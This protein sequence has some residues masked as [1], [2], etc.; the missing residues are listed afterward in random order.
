VKLGGYKSEKKKSQNA[1]KLKLRL[2]VDKVI[3]PSLSMAQVISFIIII[4][5]RASHNYN[6]VE[7]RQ[8]DYPESDMIL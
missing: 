1:K 4:L 6:H 2:I 3:I 8:K 5:L 7:A